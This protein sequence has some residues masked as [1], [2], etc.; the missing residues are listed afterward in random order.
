MANLFDNDGSLLLEIL[1]PLRIKKLQGY[2]T[3]WLIKAPGCA[4]FPWG[5]DYISRQMRLL[6]QIKK[7]Y[8]VLYLATHEGNDLDTRW[9]RTVHNET[10]LVTKEI[11]ADE[12]WYFFDSEGGIIYSADA[13]IEDPWVFSKILYNQIGVTR[14]PKGQEPMLKGVDA[15]L[16]LAS[17]NDN[18][19]WLIG[20]AKG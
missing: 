10:Y 18:I 8:P 12:I 14:I 11:S 3:L 19:F 6:V 1:K 7:E 17:S 16:V 15:D 2:S 9:G 13:I 20:T 5:F 4:L